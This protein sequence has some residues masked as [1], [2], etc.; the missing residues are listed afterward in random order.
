MSGVIVL[1]VWS[2]MLSAVKRRI[3]SPDEEET[4]QVGISVVSEI[5][6]LALNILCAFNAFYLICLGSI[7]PNKDYAAYNYFKTNVH[8]YLY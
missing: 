8:C 1:I 7:T 4:I 5:A 3:W 6:D 2:L